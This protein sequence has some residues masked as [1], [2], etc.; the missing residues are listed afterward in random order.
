MKL[1]VFGATGGTGRRIVDAALAA[2]HDVIAVA[3]R[4]DAIATTHA[5]LTVVK[6]DVLDAT[7]VR[8][9]IAGCDAVLSA[10]GPSN[11]R[12]PGTVI[13]D[14]V[15]HIVAACT[16]ANVRRLVFESGIMVG[17]GRGL[18]WFGRTAL[19][20]FRR[21]NGALAADK[22]IAEQTIRDSALDWVIVRPVSLDDSPATGSYRTGVDIPL[23][24][25][26]KLSHADVAEFMVKAASDP[27]VVHTVQDIGH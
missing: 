25:A 7:S 8:E 19:G 15:V 6:G 9:A 2:G 14:G 16:T 23:R 13:S 20:L 22:R 17:D 11:N 5:R 18:P 4:P 1:V 3:R 10:I 12:R 21:L 24:L 27:T 26:K